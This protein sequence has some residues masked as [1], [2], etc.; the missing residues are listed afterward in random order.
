MVRGRE[1]WE[2]RGWEPCKAQE[3]A[4]QGQTP[5]RHVQG[6]VAVESPNLQWPQSL[7]SVLAAPG[8][9]VGGMEKMK[10]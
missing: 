10:S 6:P 7:G 3:S 4:G 9:L 8:S 2:L 1:E 5:A